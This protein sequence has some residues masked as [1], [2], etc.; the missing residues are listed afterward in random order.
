ML[1][2]LIQFAV[3]VGL[4]TMLPGIDTAQVLRSATVGG[5]KLAYATLGGIMAGV[6][7]WGIGAAVGISAL[8]LASE[9]AYDIVRFIGAAYLLWLGARIVWA[10]REPHPSAVDTDFSARTLWAAFTR[11]AFIAITNPKNG[12]FYIAVLPQFLP[13]DMPAFIAGLL[14]STIHNVECLLWFSMLIW[15]THRARAFFTRP[16]VQ[17]WMERISGAALMGFGVAVFFE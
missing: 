7:V 17:Q 6:W 8:L 11:A 10:A 13:E 16:R 2:D 3:V 5:P 1:S 4:L 9:T 14:L 15:G 12:L